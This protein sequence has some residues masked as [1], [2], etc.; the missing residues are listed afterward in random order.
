MAMNEVVVTVAVLMAVVVLLGGM[1]VGVVSACR[2]GEVEEEWEGPGT[3]L[4]TT[5]VGD[6]CVGGLMESFIGLSPPEGPGGSGE[7][8][9]SRRRSRLALPLELMETTLTGEVR[10][11]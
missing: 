5:A 8:L 9:R 1:T 10:S 7:V 2:G 4:G 3:W 11:D 6:A